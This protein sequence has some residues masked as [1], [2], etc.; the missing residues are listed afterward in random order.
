[1]EEAVIYS[2]GRG[3]TEGREG[4]GRR[5]QRVRGPVWPRTRFPFYCFTISLPQQQRGFWLPPQ[6]GRALR[7]TV[8]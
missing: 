7:V 5:T 6:S 3:S 2:G 8:T 4:G 1:M